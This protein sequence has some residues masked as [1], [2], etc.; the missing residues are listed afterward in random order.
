MNR[1]KIILILILTVFM[2]SSVQLF[3]EDKEKKEKKKEKKEN[4]LTLD[5]KE[6]DIRDVLR[7]LAEVGKKNIVISSRVKGKISI[8]LRE[9]NW[10]DALEMILSTYG[11]VADYRKNYI[12]IL[13]LEELRREEANLPLELKVINLKYADAESIAEVVEDFIS[14]R[15]KVEVNISTNTIIV[16]DT[17]IN[18][19]KIEELIQQLD[20]RQPQ[21]FIE[22]MLLDVKV[23]NEEQLGVEWSILKESKGATHDEQTLY[24]GAEVDLA[25]SGTMLAIRYGKSIL[26]KTDLDALVNLWCHNKQAEILANPRVLTLDNQEAEI[27][28]TEA[29]P[30]EQTTI[31]DEGTY[32]VTQFTEAGVKLKVKPHVTGD[33]IT[34]NIVLEESIFTGLVGDQPAI[35]K[36]TATLNM[37]V[38]SGETIVIGGLRKRDT[39]KTVDKIPVLGDIPLIGNLF[40]R[41]T[42][43]TTDSELLLF[44]TPYIITQ[45]TMS[46]QDRE[47]L[48]KF[49][50][51]KYPEIKKGE[52]K[53][54]KLPKIK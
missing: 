41:K 9:V 50:E 11:L 7:A 40:R 28:L 34:S 2:M 42:K 35:D 36:R 19:E 6:A 12:R 24:R 29:I 18:L 33:L 44:L 38:R 47:K 53:P 8:N 31:T 52:I 22:A 23:S 17:K 54:M 27:S 37:A 3:S 26:D 4:L 21:I 25:A 43:T 30:Y 14:E 1:R 48:K 45:P 10:K 32:T 5:F 46:A 49:E 13:T 51:F 16:S 15:G 20:I 39:T